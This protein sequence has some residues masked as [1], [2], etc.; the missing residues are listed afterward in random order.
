MLTLRHIPLDV[1]LALLIA[2]SMLLAG[3]AQAAHVFAGVF[4]VVCAYLICKTFF[5]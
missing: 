5:D 3:L 1:W 2:G 4:G